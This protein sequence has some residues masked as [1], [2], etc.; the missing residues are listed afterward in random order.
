MSSGFVTRHLLRRERLRELESLAGSTLERLQRLDAELGDLIRGDAAPPG[1]RPEHDA[2]G[3]PRI[4][5]LLVFL[6]VEAARHSA[7]LGHD[8]PSAEDL[9]LT[10]ELL[11]LAVVVH[12]TALGRQGG[13]RRRA[14][15]RLLGGTVGWLGG[16]HLTLRALELARHEGPEVLSELLDAMREA[17]DGH[18]L[19]QSLRGRT[20][21]SREAL[22]HAENHTGV[23]FSFACRAG[24]RL[25]GAERPIVSGLGRYGRHAGVAWH[26]AEDLSLLE[27]APADESWASLIADRAEAGRPMLAVSLAAAEDPVVSELWEALASGDDLDAADALAERV[28]QSGAVEASRRQLLQTSWSARRAL[29]TLPPSPHRDALDLLVG[30]LIR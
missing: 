27:R 6:S 5:P 9:A 15:R 29:N 8:A 17:A 13:R 28:R 3:V 24:G 20:A 18:A 22:A 14:A 2:P 25:A 10:A 12:D 19:A 7:T 1:F 26:L 23:V 16:H 11:H 4:R 21:T 30:I